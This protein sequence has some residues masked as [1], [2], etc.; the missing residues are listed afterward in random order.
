MFLYSNMNRHLQRRLYA[1]QL[2]TCILFLTALFASG[3]AKAQSGDESEYKEALNQARDLIQS[4]VWNNQ[5]G[6]GL[7]DSVNFALTAAE[8]AKA[9]W[10]EQDTRYRRAISVYG[11][12]MSQHL[13]GL[14]SMSDG[15]TAKS[16]ELVAAMTTEAGS[17][18]VHETQD[19]EVAMM[20]TLIK[21]RL[22]R[23]TGDHKEALKLYDF[24][25]HKLE[26]M[27]AADHPILVA[28]KAERG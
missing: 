10:G 25:V 6:K 3:L 26:S 19:G 28:V 20:A 14:I 22:E 16:A 4:L 27:V 2:L 23:L 13:L 15:D 11:V 18:A 17:I 8:T 7:R 5:Y 21:A 24:V 9:S 1:P 12:A